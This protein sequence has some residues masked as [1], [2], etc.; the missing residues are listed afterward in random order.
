MLLT[1]RAR[2]IDG[3]RPR[4]RGHGITQALDHDIQPMY[5]VVTREIGREDTFH[6]SS[7]LPR[8]KLLIEIPLVLFAL[9]D[10]FQHV[11]HLG[12]VALAK[13]RTKQYTQKK[14][15]RRTPV[16]KDTTILDQALKGAR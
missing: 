5:H 14:A 7:F 3:F 6:R 12:R 15:L 13:M 11:V 1:T 16:M 2:L 4:S 9:L 8:L 10:C